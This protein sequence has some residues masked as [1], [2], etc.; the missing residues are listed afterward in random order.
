MKYIIIAISI[1][2]IQGT[3]KGQNFEGKVTYKVNFEIDEEKYGELGIKKEMIV[4]KMKKEG[5]YYDKITYYFQK[6]N[7]IK[8]DN[9]TKN[10]RII[11]KSDENLIYLFEQNSEYV[12]IVKGEKPSVLNTEFDNS[13]VEINELDSIKMIGNESCKL[14]ML[15]WG[16]LSSEYYW[17][18]PSKLNINSELFKNH[19]YEYLNKILTK[20]NSFPLEITKSVGKLMKITM[21]VEEIEEIDLDEKIFEIPELKKPKRKGDKYLEE[22]I[23]N[24][25]MKIKN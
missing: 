18:N 17:Y 12:T 21:T 6:G 10:K 3:L 5:E 8:E 11:Y 7:Y 22:L 19:N 2:F 24:K 13:S 23:G 16:E 1:V 15:N 20:T 14:V 4:E 9:S 25:V